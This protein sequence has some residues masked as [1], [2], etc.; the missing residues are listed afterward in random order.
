MFDNYRYPLLIWVLSDALCATH[1]QTKVVGQTASGQDERLD[2]SF[3]L[4]KG[5]IVGVIK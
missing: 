3:L 5:A 1:D 4:Q 2:A